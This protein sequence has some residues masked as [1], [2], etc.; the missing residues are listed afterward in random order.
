[1]EVFEFGPGTGRHAF[2]LQRELRRVER[3]SRAFVPGGLRFRLHLAELGSKGLDSLARHENFQEA[4]ADGTLVLHLFDI[5]SHD[6]P[7][8]YHPPGMTLA[9]PSPNPVFVITNYIL[10]SLPHDVLRISEGKAKLGRTKLEVKG[11]KKSQVPTSLKDLGERIK[12]T[13]DFPEEGVEYPAEGW[14]ELVRHYERL[15]G[16]THVPFPTAALRLCERC[17]RWSESAAVFLV[18]DKSFTTMSQLVE[19]E[20]PELVPHGGGFSF[21][22]NLHA[23]GFVAQRLGGKAHHTPSR[24]GTLDLSHLVIP[25][26]GVEEF[27]AVDRFRTKESVDDLQ[28]GYP[29]RICLD[30]VR[31]TGFD[32]QVLYELSDHILE[33]LEKEEE[34]LAEMEEELAEILPRV[35]PLVFALPD[36][37]DT[38]FEIGRI[39]YRI[40]SY[41][42]ARQAFHMSL[43]QYGEDAR[44]FFNLGLIWYY[45]ESYQLAVREFEKALELKSDYDDAKKWLKK[46]REKGAVPV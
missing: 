22:A 5:T 31:L 37:T 41:E 33:G 10:D 12:L 27:H 4:L 29:L 14:N 7:T 24:D 30:L 44:T 45:R 19:L 8:H 18:A 43:Q 3:L 40:E 28:K 23:L 11:L 1:M 38:A 16:I 35:L 42:L 15:G 13:F 26:P 34:N 39:A 2:L 32:P 25:A 46:A 20:A 9:L 17:R 6:L 36:D 21:N